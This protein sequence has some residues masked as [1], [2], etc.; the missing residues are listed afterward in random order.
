MEREFGRRIN[1]DERNLARLQD[2]TR[3]LNMLRSTELLVMAYE[4]G[5]FKEFKDL[6]R[7]ALSAALYNLKFTGCAVGFD[8]IEEFL[9]SEP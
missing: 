2:M 7:Q 5:Y 1:F 3:S 6:E 8:E 9:A 4:R